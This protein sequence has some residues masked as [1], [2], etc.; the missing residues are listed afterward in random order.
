[1][2]GHHAS[3]GRALSKR[4]SLYICVR[5]VLKR[6]VGLHVFNTA[7]AALHSRCMIREK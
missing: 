7:I 6:V 4:I 5:F 1:M 2:A 3:K